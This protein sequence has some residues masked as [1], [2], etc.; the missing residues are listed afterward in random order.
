MAGGSGDVEPRLCE[1]ERSLNM[2]YEMQAHSLVYDS[3]SHSLVCPHFCV[4]CLIL[5]NL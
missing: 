5:S 2:A 1:L 4:V 3:N